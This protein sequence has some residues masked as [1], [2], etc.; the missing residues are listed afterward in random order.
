MNRFFIL[1]ALI[2]IFAVSAMATDT[3]VMTM[4]ENNR[5][6]LDEA[7][8]S[9]F[10][11]RTIEYPNLAIGEFSNDSFTRFGINWKFGTDN[12]WVL[13]T[14]I[15]ES[16]DFMPTMYT[17][18]YA[19]MPNF[20]FF[21]PDDT[22]R[23]DLYYGRHLGDNNF[24]ANFNYSQASQEEPTGGKEG[25]SQFGV[26]FGLTPSTGEWDLAAGI[27]FGN[28]T[29]EDAAG[30]VETEPDGYYDASFAG[31]YF[32][33]QGPNYV[34]IPHA[35][36]MFGKH[37]WKNSDGSAGETEKMMGV[38]LGI[39]LNYTPSNSVL[40]VF[41]AGFMYQKITSEVTAASVTVD[42]DEETYLHMPYFKI[43]LDADV[44]KWMDIRLGA[45][46]F[47]ANDKSTNAA[48]EE[49]KFKNPENDTYLGFGF[50]WGNLHVD[51]YTDP[52]MFL[53][54]F[55][56]LSGETNTMNAQLSVVY[57]MM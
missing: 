54:G 13:G 24:G 45:T 12:P 4:G 17:T 6:L 46:T 18:N 9:L 40:A 19:I 21:N 15:T 33:N 3:R 30:T 42:G 52:G 8:M 32:I 14:Y 39:G 10:P 55:N 22:R 50:H 57:E 29:D 36:L 20:T 31:R 7:N 35:E 28:W 27:A 56:F 11:G 25:I 48:G 38:D 26:K 16:P 53:D 34:F 41:D 1:I 5:V 47:W 51:A 44:F 23:I 2:L 49:T 37:G 43:G